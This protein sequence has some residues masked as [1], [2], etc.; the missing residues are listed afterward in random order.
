MLDRLAGLVN[1]VLNKK[2]GR[3][4]L[5]QLAAALAQREL[6]VRLGVEWL[7]KK[8][9]ILADIQADGEMILTPGGTPDLSPLEPVFNK[10]S[11]CLEESRAYR[12][13]FH[14]QTE[15]NLE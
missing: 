12:K 14:E 13:L 10:L 15:I 11:N 6:A 5:S 8:G 1:F 7:S 2:A 4:S 9:L 3:T